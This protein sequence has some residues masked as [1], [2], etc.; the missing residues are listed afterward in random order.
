PIPHGGDSMNLSQRLS[1]GL[2]AAG[3]CLAAMVGCQQM[4]ASPPPQA[5][6]AD[7]TKEKPLNGQQVADIQV[8]L[9]RSLERRGQY[10]DALAAYAEALKRDPAN[11]DVCLRMAILYD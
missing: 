4:P 3:T 8:A 10:E 9:G 11:G 7:S 2:L 1:I 6:M 5:A